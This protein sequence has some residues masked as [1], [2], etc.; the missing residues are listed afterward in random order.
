MKRNIRRRER[1][2]RSTTIAAIAS[3]AGASLLLSSTSITAFQSPS[4]LSTPP[5]ALHHINRNR[6]QQI[7]MSKL[8]IEQT[9][10]DAATSSSSS[11]ATDD[12]PG[13]GGLQNIDVLNERITNGSSFQPQSS[14]ST[15]S[16][17]NLHKQ[18]GH[19]D[20]SNNN[21]PP[22]LQKLSDKIGQIDESRISSTPEYLSG[23]VPTLFTN[24]HYE[25][26]E[27]RNEHGN[28]T[29]T[30]TIVRAKQSNEEADETS[31]NLDYLHPR[32]YYAARQ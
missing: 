13:N 16:G 23:E 2:P 19:D 21:L 18:N 24:I 31:M 32:H 3:V 15:S 9:K 11:S 10:D 6:I 20:G 30:I 25:T 17:D 26:I 27:R 12:A 5:L 4:A 1:P 29:E 22:L 28:A 8:P 14:S 7:Q